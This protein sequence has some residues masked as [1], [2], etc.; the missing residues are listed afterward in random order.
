L[1]SKGYDHIE[2]FVVTP[3]DTWDLIYKRHVRVDMTKIEEIKKKWVVKEFD[4]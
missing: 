2:D 3:N 4:R 1:I